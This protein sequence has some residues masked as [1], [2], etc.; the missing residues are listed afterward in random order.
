[1]I[2]KSTMLK[3]IPKKFYCKVSRTLFTEEESNV[4]FK[5]KLCG[6]DT[7]FAYILNFYVSEAEARLI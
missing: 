2:L 1:M 7:S 6:I 3:E 4:N 5:V